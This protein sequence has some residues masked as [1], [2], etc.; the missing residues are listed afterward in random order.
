MAGARPLVRAAGRPGA[1]AARDEGRGRPAGLLGGN[2]G[3]P[4]RHPRRP[5]QRRGQGAGAAGPTGA[6]ARRAARAGHALGDL[7]FDRRPRPGEA[8]RRALGAGPPR[9]RRSTR[10]TASGCSPRRRRTARR[11]S[12]SAPSAAGSHATSAAAGARCA[13]RTGCR[14]TRWWRCSR[15]RQ[16]ATARSG[17]ERAAAASPRWRTGTW[18]GPG[19]A[20]RSFASDDALALAELRLPGR[21]PRAVGRHAL[22]RGAARSRRAVPR[23]VAARS[24]HDALRPGRHRA[25]DRP[26]QRRPHL[27]RDAAR[28]RA[29]DAGEPPG[30]G[31][32][33]PHERAL[34]RRRR[35]AERDGQ[36][37]AD[38]R[39]EGA[40]LD[41]DHRRHRAARPRA[42]GQLRRSEG[43]A[44]D[45]ARAG[46]RERAPDPERH[47]AAVRRARRPVRVRPAHPAARGGRALPHA[48]RGL[49]RGALGLGRSVP[50][51]LHQPAGARVRVP[52]RGARRDRAALGAGRADLL[53]PAQ[54]VAASV[55][56]RA[57][58]GAGRGA[59]D[60]LPARA[61]AGAAQAG[62]GASRRSS[63][64]ARISCP[65]RTRGS[66][67]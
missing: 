65:R 14:P 31:S 25:V 63:R 60:A 27:P 10:T 50:E 18:C 4:R 67:S 40:H 1:G 36:L 47:G 54:P 41:P 30:R 24:R 28:R 48:A 42:R 8:G 23:L 43:A 66:R 16:P 9:V 38:A 39:L 13:S 49:R 57:R 2:R 62:R 15:P 3:R 55:G 46:D 45:R 32:G 58:G 51:D 35:P 52:R 17:S 33:R 22:R 59:R 19:T 37:G 61:R 56:D 21:P 64:S 11:C 7:G 44:H 53:G 6:R 5:R 29:A 12:G 34:R 20:A 26:G